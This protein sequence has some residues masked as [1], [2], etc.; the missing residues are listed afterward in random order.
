MKKYSYIF[1][2]LLTVFSCQKDSDFLTR[3]PTD[4]LEYEEVW[5]DERLA[6]AAVAD[7]YDRIPDYQT[8]ESWARFTNFDEAFA[9]N[10]GDYFRHK[11][12]QY[13][14]NDNILDFW[15]TDNESQYWQDAYSF[16][17]DINLFI[18]SG[19]ETDQMQTN[20]N[21]I[22]LKNRFMAEAK[23]IRAIAYFELVKRVGGVPIV[24]EPL[25][26]DDSG[27][28]SYLQQPRLKEHEVY[29]FVI[30]ELEAI[31]DDL[32]DEANTKSRATQAA[33]L[34]LEARAA[35]YAASIAKYGVNTPQVSL[36]GEEV[37]ISAGQANDYY[38]KALSAAERIINS[39]TYA[40]YERNAQDLSA[41]FAD[42][43]LDKSANPEVIFVK[44]FKLQSGK[45]HGFTLANQPR[46][47]SEEVE[48]GRIN[49]SLNLVQSFELLDN[50]YAPLA[51]QSG[52]GDF[53]YYDNP[54]DL[55]ANRDAR[56]AGTVMIPG[57]T[58]K[59]ESVDIWAGYMLGN[60][61]IVTS[62]DPGG[63]GQLPGQSASQ[64]VV[65]F[66]GPID[67]F[68]WTAQTGFYLRKYVD[69]TP[70]AG[71]I[72]TQSEVWWIRFRYGEV[73][74]NAAEA[75]F[76]LGDAAKAA[77]YMNQVRRRAGFE[78]PLTP[79][80]LSFDRLVHERKVELAFEGHQLWDMKRWRLAHLVWNGANHA[81]TANIG[82][83]AEPSTRPFGVW[84]YQ[85][86]DPGN[87]N[88]GKWVFRQIIPREV[89][90]P[91]RF[92][93]GNYYSFISDDIRNR[94]PL[95]VRNP[96]Q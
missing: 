71:Q 95:I 96:N 21:E 65:G 56:L 39:G 74:L 70:G 77:G 75:A 43:F 93:L 89:T 37:G 80:Q 60:G 92:R 84:P 48:G 13:D 73:L 35:V 12:Q 85:I 45:V 83:A 62:S 4:L 94:N 50:T 90:N 66:D 19:E 68:E 63:R 87:E 40:L 52:G 26:Y 44:D 11:N 27:D 6:L 38:Q 33:A 41:N 22:A 53:L 9:S 59:G 55:F 31:F 64:Q 28:P 67:G 69:P 24:L 78:T 7:L 20:E 57:S 29:D 42:L 61:N 3:R 47:L 49:P 88:D 82:R 10:F 2:L 8:V 86:Y 79:A 1:F 18:R 76:E 5:T 54:E 17:R 58:F 36:P 51:I 32:P 16:I 15:G 23:F 25:E 34:A 72:G 81:L 30:A 46:S 91:D 14:Y